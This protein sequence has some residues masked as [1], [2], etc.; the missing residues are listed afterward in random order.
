M[1]ATSEGQVGFYLTSKTESLK[2][3]AQS[4]EKFRCR[5]SPWLACIFTLASGKGEIIAAFK[6]IEH[7]CLLQ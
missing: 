4:L 2:R 1:L 5:Q 3:R 6:D 7:E